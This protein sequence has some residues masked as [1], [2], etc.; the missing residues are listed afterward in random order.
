MALEQVVSDLETCGY[1]VA[2]PI[3]IPACAI[4]HDHRRSRFWFLAHANKGRKSSGPFNAKAPFLQGGNCDGGG[5]GQENG[6]PS[7]LDALHAYGN[8]V[9][10]GVPEIIGRAIM[11]A[12]RQ[13]K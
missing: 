7:E 11:L 9:V 3:E 4:G 5:L 6:F 10:P 8:A 12:D 2:P 13:F 1:E